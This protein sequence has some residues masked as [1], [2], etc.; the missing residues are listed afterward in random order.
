MALNHR[1][2]IKKKVESPNLQ[3]LVEKVH[4]QMQ[5]HNFFDF[6]STWY[7]LATVFM[8]DPY[9]RRYIRI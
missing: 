8:N 6:G 9:G 7:N 4:T 1:E 5:M 2:A 3:A